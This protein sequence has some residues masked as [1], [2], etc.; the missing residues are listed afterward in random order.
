MF[1]HH[2][3]PYCCS[4]CVGFPFSVRWWSTVVL[5]FRNQDTILSL[6]V[7]HSVSLVLSNTKLLE[8]EVCVLLWWLAAPPE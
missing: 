5:W 3:V 6:F 1:S 4:C 8:R 2:A 7:S